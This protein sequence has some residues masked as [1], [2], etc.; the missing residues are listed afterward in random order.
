M[1]ASLVRERVPKLQ[2]AAAA[3]SVLLPACRAALSRKDA[4][5]G[6]GGMQLFVLIMVK[7]LHYVLSMALRFSLGAFIIPA[8]LFPEH[9]LRGSMQFLPL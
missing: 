3:F 5:Q 1:P 2:I 6:S 9:V 7:D 4:G 8:G